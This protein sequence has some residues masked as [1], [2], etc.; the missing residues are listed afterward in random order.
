MY[1]RNYLLTNKR[2]IYQFKLIFLTGI[3]NLNEN[4]I[5]KNSKYYRFKVVK[6]SM[7]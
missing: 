7:E 3:L 5:K 2:E 1:L 6:N 4:L